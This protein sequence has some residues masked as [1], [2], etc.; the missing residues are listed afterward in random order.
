MREVNQCLHC[1]RNEWCTGTPA[2]LSAH[3]ACLDYSIAAKEQRAAHEK[4][5]LCAYRFN[6]EKQLTQDG[7]VWVND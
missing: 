1:G 4:G 7:F 6:G 5:K 3:I 2:P